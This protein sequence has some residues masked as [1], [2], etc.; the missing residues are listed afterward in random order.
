MKE[1][2]IGETFAKRYQVIEDLGK[3]GMGRVYKVLDK[4]IREVVALKILK[5]EIAE[6]E[7]VIERFRNELKLARKISHK[8][9]CGMYHLSKD[10]NDTH[11][12]TMEYVPG[13]DLKSLIRRMGQLTLKKA[14]FIGRQ[15]CE[16]LSEA[17]RLAVVHR[18]LKSQNIMIDQEGHARI[19][20]FGI[21]RSLMSDGL[22]DTNAIIGTPEYMAPEQVD[23]QETD[24]RTDIYSLGVILFE[25]VA[26]RVPFGGDTAL[27]VAFK[28]KNE[29]PP[30]PRTFN[31]QV[32][33]D[34]SRVIM[35]CLE[36]DKA[37]RYES[38]AGLCQDLARVEESISATGEIQRTKMKTLRAGSLVKPRRRWLALAVL[39]V[40]LVLGAYTVW[41][42]FWTSPPNAYENFISLAWVPSGSTE[43]QQD[44][45]EFL[46]QRSLAA[47]TRWYI[48]TPEDV[49]IYKKRTQDAEARPKKPRIAIS[50]EVYP[51]LIGGFEISM[52]L[53]ARDKSSKRTF[54]CK[55]YLDFITNQIDKIHDFIAG[56]SEGIV[57]GIEGNRTAAQIC[58]SN[59]DALDHFLKGEEAWRKLDPVGADFEYRTA[60]ENDADFSLAHLR[61]AEV[62]VFRVD[63]ESARNH[64]QTALAKKDRLIGSDLLRLQALL[65]RIDSKPAEERLYLGKLIEEFPFRKDYHYEFAES[66]FHCGDADEA[67]KHYAKALE[68]DPNY[69]A[70]H[71]HIAFCYAWIGDHKLA[72]EHFKKYVQL[73]NT[74]NS[75]DSLAAGYRLAGRYD[76][77]LSALRKGGALSPSLDYLYGSMARNYILKGALSKA[78]DALR[79]QE[80]VAK[81]DST[82]MSSAFYAAYVEFLKGKTEACLQKLVPLRDY[83][84]QKQF[85]RNMDEAACLP[86][87]LTGV[88]AAKRRDGRSLRLEINR[89][90]E[91]IA[92]NGVSATNFFPIYKFHVHL[93]ILEAV[94]ESD[95]AGVLR[96][97]EDGKRMWKRMGYWSS[98]FN[99]AFFFNEYAEILN[100]MGRPDEA[101]A[102]LNNA[103]LYN[104]AYAGTHVNLAKIHLQSGDR[105]VA[106]REYAEARKLLAQADKDFILVGEADKIG[107]K[108]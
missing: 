105:E 58:S 93:M 42:I 66:Y 72:E 103:N 82:K 47:S 17:H 99:S 52:S 46:V 34:L 25:M 30:E 12:L 5:P 76:E 86:S 81:L 32:P 87:W 94:L 7:R 78:S 71:N 23:G 37:K 79:Q 21:A 26:G 55:G 57:G 43:V 35:K 95:V 107:R 54:D 1:L 40:L 18:D 75:Y 97:I 104:P 84:S 102:L 59:R 98:L 50:G 63:R 8:N 68:L 3:G 2:A 41:K 106:R 83:Y 85:G 11:Y 36:K 70:A 20:D 48:Y 92:Q 74:A 14:V 53:K 108:L 80:S 69:S 39:T 67:V 19:M 100:G 4:E 10:E 29:I 91:K 90:K 13:E 51:K 49:L 60:L 61:L 56:H 38:A 65:A 15:I 73:D 64:L 45:I 88:I 28:Q 27:S 77:A 24:P 101:L 89:M 16:G 6:D 22:T 44:L 9:I 96:H 62:L 31:S 33:E